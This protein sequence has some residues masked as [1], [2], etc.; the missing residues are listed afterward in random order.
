M[1]RKIPHD[2]SLSE[3]DIPKEYKFGVSFYLEWEILFFSVTK[4]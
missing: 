3:K 2:P 1:T 4:Y